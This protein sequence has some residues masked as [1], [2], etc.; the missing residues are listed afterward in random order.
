MASNRLT[1]TE[2]L[3]DQPGVV[4]ALTNAKNVY[5]KAV[6]YG[7]F[8]NSADYSGAASQDLNNVVAGVDSAGTTK[9][10]AS[11]ST[12]LFLLDATDLSLDNVSALT[13]T[14]VTDRWRFTQF[15]NYLIAAGSPNTLQYYDLTTTG[16]FANLSS[17]APKASFVT[18]VRD[19]VVSGRTPTNTNRV[20]WSGINDATT[21]TSSAVTQSD[22]Q[23]LPDGGAVAGIT[24][25]EFGLVLCER[26]IY[27][28][29]YVGA[30]LVFQFDNISRNRGCYEPNS[31]IQWQ[32]I[33]YFL[34][35]DGF[36]ACD[37]QNVVPIGAEKVNRF[38]FN[39]LSESVM[40]QMSAA[41][42][43]NRNLILWGYPSIEQTYRVLMY[44]PQTQ[45]WSYAD[46]T[47]DRIASSSSPAVNMEGLDAFSA[48]IDALPFSL[49]SRIWLGGKLTLAGVTGT[50][51]VNFSGANKTGVIE[52][53]DIGEGQ[54]MMVTLVKPIVDNGSASVGI[55]SRFLLSE[56]PSFSAQTN[57][58]SENRVGLRSVGKYHRLRVTPTGD[59]WTTAIGV[60]IEMQPAG[61]R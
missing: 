59:N 31:V 23:D 44:H 24:G 16:N 48:S 53:S 56:Q 57:A 2:W 45:R 9:V 3:P 29:S 55:A 8:P 47:V 27:R 49:D 22:F 1:F 20:Q 54:T 15:G 52:T 40:T 28:M 19:F 17:D 43:P 18:V 61:G 36:Y 50:K 35:D 30:P 13:Y 34:S 5:P 6:G 11:G 12:L 25:G 41:V 10:F 7:P 38:F 32:G 33:T 39:D 21:W 4:G 42:D 26:S 58:D 14:A 46:T 37:G 60:D 51:I